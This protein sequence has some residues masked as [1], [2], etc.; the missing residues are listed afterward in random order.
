MGLATSRDGMTWTKFSGNP[1]L[2]VGRVGAW[3][4]VV[5]KLPVVR[6]SGERYFLFYS[7]RDGQTKQI[8]VATSK[9]LRHWTKHAKNPVEW[10]KAGA[11][12]FTGEKVDTVSN[13]FHTGDGWT[14]VYEQQDRIY[15]AVL[16]RE[17]AVLDK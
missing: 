8:A 13:P 3:D 5:A 14:I 6:K 10:K 2:D 4:S 9:D 16:R 12:R 11:G 1:I 15:R 17:G 7:G